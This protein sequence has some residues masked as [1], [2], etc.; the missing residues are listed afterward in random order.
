MDEKEKK[1]SENIELHFSE[2]KHKLGD[3]K[4]LSRIEELQ[5]NL[6]SQFQIV[7]NE[8]HNLVTGQSHQDELN[9]NLLAELHQIGEMLN[10]L[11]NAHQLTH[12]VVADHEKGL[13]ENRKLIHNIESEMQ[14]IKS[15][16]RVD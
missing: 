1:L 11:D 4:L 13:K 2:E 14:K 5:S 3:S 8:I 15:L 10:K 16:H 9:S 12:R 7:R 6:K